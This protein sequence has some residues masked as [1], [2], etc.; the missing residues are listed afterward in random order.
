MK[1][2]V[3]SY[4][5]TDKPTTYELENETLFILIFILLKLIFHIWDFIYSFFISKDKDSLDVYIL[6]S[7]KEIDW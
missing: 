5:P 7:D 3:L 6:P 4:Y 2:S 1:I